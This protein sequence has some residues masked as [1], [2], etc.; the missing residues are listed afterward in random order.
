M[1]FSWTSPRT[2]REDESPNSMAYVLGA[3][4]A[5]LA[6]GFVLNA[7][8]KGIEIHNLTELIQ[9]NAASSISSPRRSTELRLMSSN[10]EKS[11]SSK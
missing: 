9:P 11:K 6:T 8:Q 7:S 1:S 2:W 4:G 10:R 3:Y 5:C